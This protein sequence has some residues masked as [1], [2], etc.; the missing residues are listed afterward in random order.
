MQHHYLVL[1]EL[2]FL[3]VGDITKGLFRLGAGRYKFGVNCSNAEI[4]NFLL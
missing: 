2:A 1:I 4:A 3:T